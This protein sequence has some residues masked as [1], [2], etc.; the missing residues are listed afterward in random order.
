MEEQYIASILCL[1]CQVAFSPLLRGVFLRAHLFNGI[2]SPS[3][4]GTIDW[5]DTAYCSCSKLPAAEVPVIDFIQHLLYLR[6]PRALNKAGVSLMLIVMA[7]ANTAVWQEPQQLT[8]LQSLQLQRARWPGHRPSLSG[9]SWF[10]N[11]ERTPTYLGGYQQDRPLEVASDKP[12][13]LSASI[14]WPV[15]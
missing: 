12:S 11:L 13:R 4:W 8:S 1:L 9:Q 15:R 10:S 2:L 3:Q 7:P 5:V 14:S 6:N